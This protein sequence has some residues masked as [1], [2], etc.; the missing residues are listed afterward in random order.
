[1][2]TLQY[3]GSGGWIIGRGSDRIMTAPFFS[4]PGLIR[5]GIGRIAPDPS[6]I[7][8]HL[9]DVSDIDTILA[10]HSHY[11]HLMDLPHV[12]IRCAQDVAIYGNDTMTHVLAPIRSRAR[13]VSVQSI[14]GDQQTSRG[15]TYAADRRI[16]FMSLRSEHAPHLLGVKLFCGEVTQNVA[17]LPRRATGWKEGQTLAFL[18]DFLDGDE[19]RFRL[20]YQDSCCRPGFAFPPPLDRPVDLA[21]LCVASFSQTH[22]YPEAI[23]DRLRPPHLLLGHWENF[24][25]APRFDRKPKPVLL[26][27][28][29]EFIRRMKAAHP[30]GS[31]ALPN[32]GETFTF[33]ESA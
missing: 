4:N 22:G 32:P 25:S 11:D 31:W 24:F 6:R 1:M 27:N 33:K 16:R 12:V 10:G 19:I 23:L 3:L 18:V 20:H 15:W 17:E 30:E 14:A 2:L 7:D 29:D 5:T 26:S 8:P 21:I 13:L 28:P 9:P